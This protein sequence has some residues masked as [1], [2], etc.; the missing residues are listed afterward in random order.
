MSFSAPWPS[1]PRWAGGNAL[2]P[3][4]L[5]C[6]NSM[7]GQLSPCAHLAAPPR[8]QR[9]RAAVLAGVSLAPNSA[10]GASQDML[11]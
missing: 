4:G 7:K 8:A 11:P 9:L 5:E 2:D 3:G 1:S 10:H 6:T